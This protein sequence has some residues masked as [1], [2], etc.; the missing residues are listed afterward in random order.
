LVGEVVW[1]VGDDGVEV[2]EEGVEEEEEEGAVTCHT[3]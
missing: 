2:E 3:T 1:V